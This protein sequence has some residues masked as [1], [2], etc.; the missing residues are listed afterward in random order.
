MLRLHLMLSGSIRIRCCWGTEQYPNQG[1]VS[2]PVKGT[3]SSKGV[4]LSAMS[5][6]TAPPQAV[7][8]G[9]VSAYGHS[10][11]NLN[12]AYPLS[13]SIHLSIASQVFS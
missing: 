6:N 7:S 11:Y 9:Q 1:A 2:T 3:G 4:Y 13:Y 10:P 12:Q 5:G 8:L